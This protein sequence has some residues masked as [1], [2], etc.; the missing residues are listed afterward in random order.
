MRRRHFTIAAATA[1]VGTAAAMFW[2][3]SGDGNSV[4]SEPWADH[5]PHTQGFVTVNGIKIE[6]LDWG[7]T[8]EPMV[9]LAGLGVTAHLYDEIAPQ[10]A[11]EFRV[12]GLTRRGFGASDKP[13]DGYDLPTLVSD[14]RQALDALGIDRAIVVGHSYGAQEAA[15]FATAFP[16]RV[17]KVIYLDGAYRLT[18]ELMK[19]NEQVFFAFVPQPPNRGIA[20]VS[21]LMKWRRQNT[22]G[23][24]DAS[25]TDFRATRAHTPEGGISLEGST[26]DFVFKALID[27]WM[28]S[29]PD[30]L[31]VKAP[32]L[33]IFADHQ[34]EALLAKQDR[35]ARKKAEPLIKQA[36]EKQC[37]QVQR[38]KRIVTNATVVEMADTDHMCFTQRPQE[39]VQHMRSFLKAKVP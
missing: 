18:P 5:S 29:G 17:S 20:T 2:L 36:Y 8:G 27:D 3:R 16:E 35:A 31:E 33:A 32:G 22:V 38:F 6:Y 11:N 24:T 14:V 21:Q 37:E 23:W 1:L 15:A 13:N 10:F 9:F 26:P 25:E 30:F 39:V 7:G 34:L 28:K 12:I 19:L 4:P